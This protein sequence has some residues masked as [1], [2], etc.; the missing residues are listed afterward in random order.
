MRAAVLVLLV[1]MLAGC[2]SGDGG[3][4]DGPPAGATLALVP[5]AGC[6]EPV[7]PGVR[8]REPD[9][10]ADPAD[11]SRLAVAAMVSIPSTR[12]A[13]R[14]DL[15]IWTAVA[16]SSDGGA[17]WRGEDLRGWA[18]DTEVTAF[19]GSVLVGDPILQFLPDGT[20]L[21][22][23]LQLRPEGNLDLFALRFEG[24]DLQPASYVTIARGAYGDPSLAQVPGTYQA[25]YNDKP[26]V[27]LD[28]TTG[29]VYVGW[30]WRTNGASGSR[31]VPVASLSHDGGLTWLPPVML[32][33]GLGAGAFAD[34]F[35]PAVPFVS[36]TGAHVLWWDQVAGEVWQ[37]DAPA[38]TLAF[39][40]GRKLR[41]STTAFGGG[42]G[43][44]ASGL[45]QVATAPNGLDVAAVW[46]QEGDGYDTVLM[47]S[48][49][50]GSTW[51]EPV[52]AGPS[53][54]DQLLPTVA[55]RPDGQVAVLVLDNSEDPAGARFRAVLVTPG[56]DGGT[57]VRLG[58]EAFDAND[59]GDEAQS[60]GDYVGLNGAGDGFAAA[61]Q[62]GRQGTA[63]APYSEIH[64]C[65]VA[66]A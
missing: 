22:V 56:A 8:G 5:Q 11:P 4:G 64:A 32:F 7:F 46:T 58:G 35:G 36:A 40:E 6:D 14:G 50:G 53:A 18:G 57:V 66:L 34:T 19:T 1:P 45:L 54:G 48:R 51:D 52:R 16:R 63:D 59:G 27:A 21:H 49:D 37:A 62:D 24:E 31:A 26:E 39:G 10:A 55:Y 43:V 29:D 42:K 13:P 41:D 30:M 15:A 33:G 20:L 3:D 28:P 17:T 65:R 25:F 38:G 9:L 2:L 23:G 44:L 61:W 60:V 47:R 12:G